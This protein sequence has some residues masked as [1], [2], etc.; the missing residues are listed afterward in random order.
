MSK[1]NGLVKFFLFFYKFLLHN[2]KCDKENASKKDCFEIL[3]T[4]EK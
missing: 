3:L 1:K 4:R 2:E